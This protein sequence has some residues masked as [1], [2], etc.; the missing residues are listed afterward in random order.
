MDFSQYLKP[1][2]L[3]LVPAVWGV[4]LVLKASSITNKCIPLV[5]ALFSIVL[6]CLYIL[7]TD[8]ISG[9]QSVYL[10]LFTGATQGV[11]AWVIA[12]VAYENVIKSAQNAQTS[13][14]NAISIDAGKGQ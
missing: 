10:A 7:A 12:W 11:L 1:E 4:G 9:W 13:V 6:A 3:V 5:L 14:A 2:L 8:E